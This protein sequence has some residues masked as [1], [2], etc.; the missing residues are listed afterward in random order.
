VRKI[1]D[2]YVDSDEEIEQKK[3][4]LEERKRYLQN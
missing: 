2:L 4:V 1:Y 3:T